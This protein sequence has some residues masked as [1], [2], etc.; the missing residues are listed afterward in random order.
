MDEKTEIEFQSGLTW[1]SFLAALYALCIF[2]P[3]AI[4]LSLTT[5]GVSFLGAVQISIILFFVE[6]TRFS[7]RPLTKQE[8]TIMFL[9]SSLVSSSEFIMMIYREYFVHSPIAVMFGLRNE[10]P[11]WW[12]PPTTS[13]VW[14]LRTFW[15]PDWLIPI[16]L[17]A[18]LQ[19]LA[20]AGALCYALMAREIYIEGERLPFPIQEI[21]ARMIE[22]LTERKE[23]SLAVL[24]IS[25]VISLIYGIFLYSIPAISMAAGYNITFIPIPWVDLTHD[26][27]V[28]MP[29]ASFGVATDIILI[30]LGLVL[31]PVVS[32]SMLVGS[33]LRFVI[34]NWL[35]VHLGVTIWAE[36][37]TP[38]MNLTKIFQESTL[39]L[40]ACPIIGMGFAVGLAPL[41]T[42]PKIAIDAFKALAGKVKVTQ[43]RISGKPVSPKILFSMLIT[44]GI[45]FILIYY[46]LVPEYPLW[47]LFVW[48]FPLQFV[49]M[50]VTVRLLGET[51]MVITMPNMPQILTLASGYEGVR[52]WFL[53]FTIHPGT[54]WTMNLKMCQ[55][56]KTEISSW[57]KA[58]FLVFPIA[59]LMGALYVSAFWAIAPIP[60]AMYPAPAIM[61]PVQA[62]YQALWIKRPAQFWK[63]DLIIYSFIIMLGF[64]ASVSILNLPISTAGLLAGVTTPIP[65]ML[66]IFL[67][68]IIG[69]IMACRL[70]REVYDKYKQTL[71][72]GLM[73]GEG[74][75]IIIGSGGAL[76]LR[77]IWTEPF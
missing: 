9:V 5:I 71:A 10:V 26:L 8:A 3:A 17:W 20:V 4:W 29:G 77:S 59:L 14:G 50:L 52:G 7:G 65:S 49:M 69:K 18:L 64:C 28:F 56:T 12:A 25:A 73:L 58:Y 22:V 24:S 66:T 31:P 35:T 33:I 72:A 1:R 6:F 60:S 74:I 68:T 16:G 62:M 54:M 2:A 67:G 40:W 61:W 30:G 41:L 38:G 55:L 47:A 15:H 27:E 43:E 32:I 19:I 63:P 37:W 36:H 23:E 34:I 21:N 44:V 13:E 57:I 11:S 51:G 70:G 46:S 48:E 39:Y 76:I 42:R 45:T 75:A 53:P